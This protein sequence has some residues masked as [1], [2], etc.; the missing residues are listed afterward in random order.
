MGLGCVTSTPLLPL[1]CCDVAT[2]SLG[3]R[4]RQ[5]GLQG[6]E[7]RGSSG[8]TSHTLGSVGKCEGVSPHT[9]KTTLILGNGVLVDSRN[10]RKQFHGSKLNGLW[11]FLYHWK[12]LG[13]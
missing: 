7:P 6:C 9:S 1:K 12:A 11:C 2:L 8:I 3:S 5:E 10:V 4:P 13:T